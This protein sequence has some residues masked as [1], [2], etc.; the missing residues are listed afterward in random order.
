MIRPKGP[1]TIHFSTRLGSFKLVSV[2]NE[3]V[4]GHLEMTF[5]GGLLVSGIDTPPKPVGKI[6]EEY[7]YAPLKKYAFSGEG[8]LVLD[9]T[10]RSLQWFGSDLDATFV[11]RGKL[12]LVG[13]FDRDLK[14]G[15]YWTTDPKKVQPWPANNLMEVPVPGYVAAAGHTDGGAPV[16]QMR[17]NGG[18]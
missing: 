9:G 4:S 17:K 16:P 18:S 11:G 7:T 3:P 6:R 12:R 1:G 13:E 15:E 14:T 8:K 2:E 10:F 5:K